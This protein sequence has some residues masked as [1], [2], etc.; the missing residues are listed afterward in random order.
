MRGT[1][2]HFKVSHQPQKDFILGS[3]EVKPPAERGGEM[4]AVFLFKNPDCRTYCE[5]KLQMPLHFLGSFFIRGKEIWCSC[6]LFPIVPFMYQI[7][8]P[9]INSYPLFHNRSPCLWASQIT[10]PALYVFS[11]R[12]AREQL[13]RGECLGLWNPSLGKRTAN[14][15][16]R[17]CVPMCLQG[18]GTKGLWFSLGLKVLVQ[19]YRAIMIILLFQAQMERITGIDHENGKSRAVKK[20][21]V[22]WKEG[23]LMKEWPGTRTAKRK[24][25]ALHAG[26]RENE[27]TAQCGK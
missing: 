13:V 3:P 10:P 20:G 2:G 7:R 11:L 12:F 21:E 14:A 1:A 17:D 24:K 15:L 23:E 25:R 26:R 4:L 6:S 5:A 18:C 22:C 9:A 19:G 16:G 8:R 27:V